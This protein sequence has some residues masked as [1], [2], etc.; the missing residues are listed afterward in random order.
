MTVW[1]DGDGIL[2][3]GRDTEI[4]TSYAVLGAVEQGETAAIF[5]TGG[6]GVGKTALMGEIAV[7]MR[8]QGAVSA[9]NSNRVA[10]M[11]KASAK[12]SSMATPLTIMIRCFDAGTMAV[13]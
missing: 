10:R 3:F 9:V 7:R 12:V 4:Q 2:M 13:P 6:S 8:A 11:P 5:I 1:A